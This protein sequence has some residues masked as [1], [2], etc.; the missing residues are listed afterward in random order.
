MKVRHGQLEGDEDYEYYD[1]AEDDY[2]DEDGEAV[3]TGDEAPEA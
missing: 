2:E 1:G 3:I